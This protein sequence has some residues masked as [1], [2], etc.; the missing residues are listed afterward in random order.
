MRGDLPSR[1][2]AELKSS[3][4]TFNM[5]STCIPFTNR[6]TTGAIMNV[7]LMRTNQT[8]MMIHHWVTQIYQATLMSHATFFHFIHSVPCMKPLHHQSKRRTFKCPSLTTVS[9]R[10]TLITL[11]RLIWGQV[12]SNLF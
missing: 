1:S 3:L 4:Y 10:K 9:D 7:N 12:L 6:M 11:Q 5:C 8:H 2:R